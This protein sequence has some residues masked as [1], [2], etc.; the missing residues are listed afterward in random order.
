MT[1][2]EKEAEKE[3]HRKVKGLNEENKKKNIKFVIRGP[4]WEREVVRMEIRAKRLVPAPVPGTTVLKN[5]YL[6]Q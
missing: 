3:L 4:P 1:P 2:A 6:S 5:E